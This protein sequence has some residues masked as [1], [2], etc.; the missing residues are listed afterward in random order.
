MF[1]GKK[2]LALIPA[3]GGS[4]GIPGKNL[5]PLADKPLIAW[6]IEQAR[7]CSW[8][9]RVIV[10]TDDSVIA[11]T[12]LR[13][14]AEVP[15][16]RPPALAADDASVIDVILHT[17]DWYRQR[18]QSYELVLLLQPTSP[19]RETADIE[20]ALQRLED[21]RADAVVSVCPCEHSPLWTNTLGPNGHMKDFLD[22][23]ALDNR[24]RLPTYYRLNGAIYL[25][26]T[27]YF[28]QRRGF[29]GDRTYAYI[30][31]SER[32]IDIDSLLD[33]Q[34]AEFLFHRNCSCSEIR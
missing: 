10:S 1:N 9:D 15:F 30:M 33:F 23:K 28:R 24:Q 27:E 11:E 8:I 5:R 17:L 14:D 21:C 29:Y 32:S 7:R 25:A 18:D 6:T 22:F 13:W 16:L 3:R 4:K 19:L 31:P 26:R 20:A 34:M 2:L 12:A